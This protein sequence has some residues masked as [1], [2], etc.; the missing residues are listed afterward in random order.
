MRLGKLAEACLLTVALVMG[1]DDEPGQETVETAGT[2]WDTRVDTVG[3]RR[4]APK[5]A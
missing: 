1:C 5:Q 4:L 2:D 3:V